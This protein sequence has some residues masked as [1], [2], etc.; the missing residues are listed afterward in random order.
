V[1][2]HIADG[3]ALPLDTLTQNELDWA[4]GLFEGEGCIHIGYRSMDDTYRLIATIGNTDE[5]V[6]RFFHDKFGGWHQL[7]GG[8]RTGRKPAWVWTVAGPA[9]EKFLRQILPSLRTDRV[10]TKAELGIKF[11]E[12]MGK[13][14]KGWQRRIY[15]EIRNLNRRGAD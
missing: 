8:T 14:A 4:A 9:A 15:H 10:R 5:Q 11:R 13:G 7:A 2:L 3:L 12:R 1:K 6:T